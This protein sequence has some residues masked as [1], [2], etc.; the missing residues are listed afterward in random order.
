MQVDFLACKSEQIIK[1][2]RF[3]YDTWTESALPMPQA[4]SQPQDFCAMRNALET[5]GEALCFDLNIQ[6]VSNSN[7][8]FASEAEALKEFDRCLIKQIELFTEI[9][10]P[11]TQEVS[12]RADELMK[13]A[14]IRH[15]QIF[16]INNSA[17]TH[18]TKQVI[19]NRN[20]CYAWLLDATSQGDWDGAKFTLSKLRKIEER[21]TAIES[22]NSP[23]NP[24]LMTPSQIAQ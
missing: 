3:M 10:T 2:L 20:Y 12:E 5:L 18:V 14:E 22:T 16:A 6:A 24:L 17:K 9:E 21:D 23:D 4:N 7:W 1:A 13:V 8:T 11:H 15:W 19:N